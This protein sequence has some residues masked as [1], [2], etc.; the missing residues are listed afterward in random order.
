LGVMRE[1]FVDMH[2]E[3]QASIV[4][5]DLPGGAEE[6]TRVDGHTSTD[7]AKEVFGVEREPVCPTTKQM[8]ATELQASA[9]HDC[10]R[11]SRGSDR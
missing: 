11:K 6:S 9:G 4:Q 7:Q 8:E 5:A 3:H 2:E 1:L 10:V